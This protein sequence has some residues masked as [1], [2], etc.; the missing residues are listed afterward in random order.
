MKVV[1]SNMHHHC[2]DCNLTYNAPFCPGCEVPKLGADHY[3][4]RYD[5]LEG[6]ERVEAQ[7]APR[8]P[9]DLTD[10]FPS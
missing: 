9:K 3:S 8:E 1:L 7:N 4:P 2:Q 10:I 6:L 5:G